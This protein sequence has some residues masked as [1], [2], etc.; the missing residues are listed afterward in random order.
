MKSRFTYDVIYVRFRLLPGKEYY[1]EFAA[2]GKKATGDI[3]VADLTDHSLVCNRCALIICRDS[4]A[5]V[6]RRILSNVTGIK[7]YQT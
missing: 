6:D 3:C 5:L 1:C 7:E 2:C 4:L